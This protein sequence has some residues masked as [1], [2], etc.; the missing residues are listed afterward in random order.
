[1]ILGWL[2]TAVLIAA[3][4]FA[5]W[6]DYTY[7]ELGFLVTFPAEP[8]IETGTYR[9]ADGSMLPDRVFTVEQDGLVFRITV[10]D[11]SSTTT[12]K[13]DVIKAAVNDYL[14]RGELVEDTFARID[15]E[16]GR[17]LNIAGK[18]GSRTVASVFFTAA[19]RLYLIEGDTLPG[20]KDPQSG[21]PTRFR[22]S[23]SFLN[24]NNNGTAPGG[25][26]G[27]R[28]RGGRGGAAPAPQN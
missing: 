10:V 25:G 18:D 15:T 24:A 26:R 27:G 6:Q 11:C 2:G 28:G 23:L 7:P 16:F 22:E 8:K 4:A 9:A 12:K 21:L 20:S 19:R 1:M 14:K 5:A 3:P 13:A 17:N